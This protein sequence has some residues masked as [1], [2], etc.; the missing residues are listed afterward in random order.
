MGGVTARIL[1]AMVGD[2]PLENVTAAVALA[3][4]GAVAVAGFE[5]DVATNGVSGRCSCPPTWAD[6]AGSGVASALGVWV[7]AGTSASCVTGVRGAGTATVGAAA[8]AV[9]SMAACGTKRPGGLPFM[10]LRSVFSTFGS[11][12]APEPRE[13]GVDTNRDDGCGTRA[14]APP[15]A[16][17]VEPVEP[18][19]SDVVS[20]E[21][22]NLPGSGPV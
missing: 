18:L 10:V 21:D 9:G 20:N 12:G 22:G 2:M 16:A 13:G 4:R 1:A 14:D 11:S 5:N 8:V 15:A 3:F 17:R 7:A 6:G 19:P